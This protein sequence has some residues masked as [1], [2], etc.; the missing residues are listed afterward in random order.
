MILNLKLLT[1]E[2]IPAYRNI[3]ILLPFT[4]LKRL[5]K[6]KYFLLKKHN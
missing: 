3:S 1:T 4:L 6:L 2:Q 5:P